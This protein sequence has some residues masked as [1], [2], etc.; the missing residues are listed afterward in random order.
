MVNWHTI[1]V[2]V[3]EEPAARLVGPHLQCQGLVE[4]E[5]AAAREAAHLSALLT[6]RHE[7]KLEGLEPLYG[8]DY[9]DTV[10]S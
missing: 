10:Y 2:E 3:T 5:P 9:I 6:V 7:L 1:Q 4:D 8:T